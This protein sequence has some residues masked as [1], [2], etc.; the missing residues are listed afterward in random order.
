MGRWDF[1]GFIRGDLVVVARV[2]E[3][4]FCG[5]YGVMVMGEWDDGSRAFSWIGLQEMGSA[6]NVNSM[7]QGKR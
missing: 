7:R 6:K 4:G 1:G 3:I 5:S 2:R